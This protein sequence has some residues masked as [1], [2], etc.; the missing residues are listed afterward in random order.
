MGAVDRL[1]ASNSGAN[2]LIS[3][4]VVCVLAVAY[5]AETGRPRDHVRNWRVAPI[6]DAASRQVA[7][8]KLDT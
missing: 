8:E 2:F 1:D 5:R 7:A 4:H 3:A 6:P